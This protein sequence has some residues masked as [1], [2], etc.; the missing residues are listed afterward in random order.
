MHLGVLSGDLPPLHPRPDHEGVH[1]PLDLLL[2]GLLGPRGPEPTTGLSAVSVMLSLEPAMAM[3]HGQ[4]VVLTVGV[5]LGGLVH[6]GR[7]DGALLGR[8]GDD[9]HGGV[10]AVAV[11]GRHLVARHGQVAR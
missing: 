11:V 10:E 7:E 3:A 6:G 5:G 2:L 8:G 1:R 4:L 9:A